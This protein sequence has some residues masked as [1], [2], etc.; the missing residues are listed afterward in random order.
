VWNGVTF[1]FTT[2]IRLGTGPGPFVVTGNLKEEGTN[3]AS[4]ESTVATSRVPFAEFSG[5]PNQEKP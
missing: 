2:M 3:R 1:E 5:T 4:L